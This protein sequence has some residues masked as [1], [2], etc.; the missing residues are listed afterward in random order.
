MR[1]LQALWLVN[2]TLPAQ[3]AEFVADAL[4]EDAVAVTVLAP[5]R[6]AKA[7]VEAIY[8][9]EPVQSEMAARLEI[10]A[11]VF[12]ISLPAFTI[13]AAPSL[14]WLKKV[15]EDFPPLKIARWTVHG[16]MHRDKVPNRLFALQIDAT[17]A[18]GTGE[19]PT[20]R[21][22][23]LML[24]QILKTGFRP[25]HMAD[26]GC[27]SGILAMGCVQGARSRAV[28]VDLDQDSVQIALNN[29][30]ANGLSDKIRVMCSRGYVSPVL[31][32]AAPYDLIMANIFARPLSQMAKDLK[33]NLRPGGMAILSG[34]LTTQ[35]NMVI[36]AHRMQGLALVRHMKL[37]EWSVLALKRPYRA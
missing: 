23:L 20:T 19:H 11:A 15:A 21:G 14:D 22:C 8:D 31:R 12:D 16:A 9:H 5:P 26:I 29:V 4:G 28:A 1:L 30:R 36:A 27:G 34:L 25:R 32:R 37:G 35:A 2:I 6:Q 24:D 13:R 18:F 3:A 33:K 17:N 7:T 10:L